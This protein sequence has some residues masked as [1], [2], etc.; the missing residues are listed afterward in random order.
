MDLLKI[1]WLDQR[2]AL[3]DIFHYRL[4]PV[5]KYAWRNTLKSGTDVSVP[6]Q[7]YKRSYLNVLWSNLKFCEM[8]FYLVKKLLA[9]M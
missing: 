9:H 2:P 1:N 3:E 7:L 8:C 6:V 4:I 5:G